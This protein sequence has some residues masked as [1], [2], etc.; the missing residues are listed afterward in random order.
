MT[1]PSRTLRAIGALA[2]A[3]A[4]RVMARFDRMLG[5]TDGA[6]ARREAGG[7][8]VE[9][10]ILLPAFLAV[11]MASFEASMLLTRQV[12]LERGVDI[13]TRQL[14]LDGRGTIDQATIRDEVCAR[15][16]ILPDCQRNLLIEL[17]AIDPDTFALPDTDYPCVDRSTTDE[18]T[19][20]W[21]DDRTERL[22]LMRACFSVNPIM[23]GVGMGAEL[24]NAADGT[25]RMVTATAFV[26][27]PA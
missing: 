25:I 17:V 14:R 12:M 1:R 15:A 10:V 4:G 20:G 8:T 24:V 2:W 19:A 16:R 9:F 3:L 6:A 5:L 23:P 7:A 22:I 27:E 11:F 21:V 26:V 18:E 13:A